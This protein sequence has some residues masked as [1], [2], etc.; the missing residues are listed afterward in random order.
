MAR[1]N[2]QRSVT[3]QPALL[4]SDTLSQ[5][6]T[7]FRLKDFATKH[8]AKNPLWLGLTRRRELYNFQVFEFSGT[9]VRFGVI[10]RPD[11]A[12]DPDLSM[13][14]I[15]TSAALMSGLPF[16]RV[17]LS[18]N[19]DVSIHVD[20][21]VSSPDHLG[22]CIDPW[23][24]WIE[25]A[26]DLLVTAIDAFSEPTPTR[27]SPAKKVAAEKV[28]PPASGAA[29]AIVRMKVSLRDIRPKV[30]RRLEVPADVT[31][32]RL[33]RILQSAMGWDDAHLHEFHV[34]KREIGRP[35]R[36]RDDIENEDR[37]RLQ[38][39]V[40]VKTKLQYWY[41]FGDD[42]W[43]DITIES[44][45]P[46]QPGT[47]YPHLVDGAGAAPPEDVGGVSGYEEFLAALSDPKNP[48]HDTYL[49]WVGGAFDPAA[50]DLEA[51]RRLVRKVR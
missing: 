47:T 26:R 39:V 36:F 4:V 43:H 48:E 9:A 44:I 21:Y 10:V 30:W 8:D 14:L 18:P 42:W 40:T 37:V 31:F 16:V 49:E 7:I 46:P 23:V 17:A 22:R 11:N 27:R 3:E 2:K 13:L 5:Y 33:H 24:E 1:R 19:N 6:E 41:D 12:A 28:V 38:D 32:A 15:A 51:R 25:N 45:G 20:A 34:G 50:F 29:A 35:D